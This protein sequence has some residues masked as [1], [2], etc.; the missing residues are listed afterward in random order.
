MSVDQGMIPLLSACVA[1]ARRAGS[2]IREIT[3]RGD[4]QVKEKVS[5]NIV[6]G[7]YKNHFP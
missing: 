4:L 1:A 3:E 7:E 6:H 2:I 5:Y